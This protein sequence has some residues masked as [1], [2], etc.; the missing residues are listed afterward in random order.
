[1]ELEA[2]QKNSK[3]VLK[4]ERYVLVLQLYC[5]CEH[6]LSFLGLNECRQQTA[7][8]RQRMASSLQKYLCTICLE[9]NIQRSL[10]PCGHSFC[11]SCASQ[12]PRNRCPICRANIERKL[13]LFIGDVSEDE[14]KL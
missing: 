9:H 2:K 8:V 5:L 7:Q 13:K 1:M 4:A 10:V 12:L 11:E 3:E 14:A 6:F